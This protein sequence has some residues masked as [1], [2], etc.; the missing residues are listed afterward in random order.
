MK[1]KDK[2]NNKVKII[3]LTAVG[4]L[5]FAGSGVA[6]YM[7]TPPK[8]KKVDLPLPQTRSQ[9]EG[10]E[11]FKMFT[12]KLMDEGLPGAT[13]TPDISISWEDNQVDLDGSIEF[14]MPGLDNLEFRG[15]LE[16]DY[17]AEHLDLGVAYVSETVYASIQDMRFKMPFVGTDD[18]F[19]E[20]I[21][22]FI[23]DEGNSILPT[24]DIDLGSLLGD[25]ELSIDGLDISEETVDGNYKFSI[26]SDSLLEGLAFDVYIES[27]ENY[28]LKGIG[29]NSLTYEDLTVTGLVDVAISNDLDIAAPETVD[30]PYTSVFSYLPMLRKITNLVKDKQVG[31]DLNAD[32]S[33]DNHLIGSIE[34]GIDFDI[35]EVSNI[36]NMENLGFSVDLDLIGNES[37]SNEVYSDVAL[38]YAEGNGMLNLNDAM[39][40]KLDIDSVNTLINK[41]K[42]SVADLDDSGEDKMSDLFD[43]ITSS[44]LITS[45]KEGKYDG[46]L[47]MINSLE[48]D[49]DKIHINISLESLGL[50]DQS[51]VDLLINNSDEDDIGLLGLEINNVEMDKIALNISLETR[52]FEDATINAM[53]ADIDNYSSFAFVNDIYDQIYQIAQVK[54]SG[55]DISGSVLDANNDGFSFSGDSQFDVTNK[56]GYGDID[57]VEYKKGGQVYDNHNVKIDVTGDDEGAMLFA[58]E[59][60][61]KGKFTIKTL[62]DLI[63]LVKTLLETDDVRYTKFFEPLKEMLLSATLQKVIDD[64]DYFR[65]AKN[66]VIKS[67]TVNSDATEIALCV[68]GSIIGLESDLNLKIN[69][70]AQH[71]LESVDIVDLVFGGKTI[72][73]HGDLTD[74]NEAPDKQHILSETDGNY[75]DFSD[76]VVL[77]EFAIKTSELNSYH[78]TATVS[79]GIGSGTILHLDVTLDFYI[80][81]QS[82]NVKVIGYVDVPLVVGVTRTL[83]QLAGD[84]CSVFVYEPSA[85]MNGK[86]KMHIVRETNCLGS[87]FDEKMHWVATSDYFLDNIL[88][89]LLGDLLGLTDS[90]MDSIEKDTSEKDDSPIQYEDMFLDNGFVYTESARQWNIGIDLSVLTKKSMFGGLTATIKGNADKYLTS[91]HAETSISIG[92]KLA[93]IADINVIDINPNATGWSTS[94]NNA[95]NAIINAHQSLTV[96]KDSATTL[97]QTFTDVF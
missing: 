71:E 15:D 53:K 36:A 22:L 11:H 13:I 4:I 27:D 68:G 57:F 37:S 2:K 1:K 85:V 3:S 79:M 23:D 45:I 20:L 6:A 86:G 9:D 12:Q 76:I 42:Q 87:R 46:I 30:K 74:Y 16:V 60:K 34:T 78:L 84:R 70:S 81:V 17:N 18:L 19:D 97:S 8:S 94:T 21:D 10:S 7:L 82:E 96:N 63:D 5:A 48:N 47:H 93:M 29:I 69:L 25:T 50:G 61:L 31:L 77:L 83:L 80:Q 52:P 91:L 54:K 92:I 62:N 56:Y 65:F 67:I 58:Y 73:F 72:N 55:F 49:E 28:D 75:L 95:Y 14:R 59:T 24:I 89:Y 66:D 38:T 35:S 51:E 43:F 88:Q 40:A 64:Y 44:S 33:F 39:K 41:I 32:L 90:I 26:S